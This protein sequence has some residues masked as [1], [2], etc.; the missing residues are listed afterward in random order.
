M[1]QLK[2]GSV[3]LVIGNIV[4]Q[5]TDAI[6]NAANTKLAGG[7]GVDGAI[8]RAAGP[9]LMRLCLELPANEK[10]QRCETGD[11]RTT[12]AGNLKSKIV[13]H[14]VGPFF[15]DKYEEKAHAQLRSVHMRALREAVAHNCRSIALPAISTGA[16]RFPG[17]GCR[18]D[19]DRLRL[20]VSRRSRGHRSRSIC[21]L[22]SIAL[23]DFRERIKRLETIFEQP[24]LSETLRENLV[25]QL[26]LRKLPGVLGRSAGTR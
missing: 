2:H 20:H 8:H 18:Q 11:V 23:Q 6:V 15:N 17:C 5:T 13:I 24:R 16:Y 14:A 10:G 4:E 3:E 9:E 1:R 21:P 7:G 26:Q 25:R 19:S 22:Q 12:S